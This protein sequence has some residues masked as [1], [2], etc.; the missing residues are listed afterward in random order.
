MI[1]VVKNIAKNIPGVFCFAYTSKQLPSP[2]GIEI[3]NGRHDL[4]YLGSE[5]DKISM[6]GD[7]MRLFNDINVAIKEALH[8]QTGKTD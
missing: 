1:D 7:R 2:F 5:I 4:V 6:R 8:E 3:E